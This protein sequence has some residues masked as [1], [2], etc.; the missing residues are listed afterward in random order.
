MRR[1]PVNSPHA[2]AR[3]VALTLLADG[4]ISRR[5]MNS[6]LRTGVYERLGLDPLDMQLLLEDLAR[7]L[8]E[9]GTPAWE[10]AGGLHPLVVR[11]V[12]DDVT[13]PGLRREV[14]DICRSIAESDDHLT[15]GEDA[16]LALARSQW[17]L[18]MPATS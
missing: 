15:D 18:P 3:V 11:C 7:D 5:E 14:L 8:F 9:F 1:Y 12:L 13:D 17:H 10:H 4:S 2:A 6:L 16:V